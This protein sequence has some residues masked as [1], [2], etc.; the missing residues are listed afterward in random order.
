MYIYIYVYFMAVA[1]NY[2][3]ISKAVKDNS[4]SL[5]SEEIMTI[6]P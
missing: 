2:S 1:V 6:D 4:R 3:A 5:R